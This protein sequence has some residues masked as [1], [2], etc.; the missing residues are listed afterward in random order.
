MRRIFTVILMI[1]LLAVVGG[2]ANNPEIAI[3][4]VILLDETVEAGDQAVGFIKVE[5]LQKANDDVR[6]TFMIPELGVKRQIAIREGEDVTKYI[7]AEI[8]SDAER[9]EY[10][11]RVVLSSDDFKEVKHR[12]VIV[13]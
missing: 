9:G 2:A 12:F 6:L 8:P 7:V 3:P 4:S 11:V 13:E 10:L 1:C 5:G